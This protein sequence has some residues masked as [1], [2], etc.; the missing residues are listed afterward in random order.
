MVGDARRAYRQ[1]EFCRPQDPALSRELAEGA[2]R[3][4]VFIAPVG[5]EGGSGKRLYPAADENVIAVTATD[6]SD[7]IF[8]DAN[9]CPVTCIAAPGVDVL[10]AEPG[11]AYGFL[12][13]TSIAAA[14]VSGVVALLLDAKPD[15]EL[16]AIRNLLFKTAKHLNPSDQDQASVAG[17]VDAY[18]S[19]EAITAPVESSINSK[20]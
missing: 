10:V 3:G 7:G 2:R 14:H 6:R 11:D 20:P 18:E 12:S 16:K 19:L 9:P 13:G 8:K 4:V 15:L 17:I 1:Y 5:N